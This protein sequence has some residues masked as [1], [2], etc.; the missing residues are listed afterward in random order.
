MSASAA[1]AA[2][3]APAAS[4]D[5]AR[6]AAQV[7][8]RHRNRARRRIVV[9]WVARIVLLAVCLA[10]WEAVVKFGLANAL[11]FSDPTAIVAFLAQAVPNGELTEHTV[12]TIVETLWGFVIGSVFGIVSGLIFARL[13]TLDAI[14][15]PFLNVLNALPRVALAPLFILWFGIDQP[16]KVA[17]AVSLVYFILLINTR[18]GV[19]TVPEEYII[20]ARSLGAG[21][22]ELFTK[23]ILPGAVPAIFAGLRLAAVYSLLGVVVGEMIAAKAGLG[24]QLTYYAGTFNT[25]GVFGV[26]IILAIIAGVLN[27]GMVFIEGRLLRWQRRSE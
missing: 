5:A 22:R 8:V 11:F 13:S 12:V 6:A 21:E 2:P 16:S 9:I 17:L 14:F 15:D 27:A 20:I 25:A 24:Q 18:A 23:V 4:D 10:I 7:A 3:A 19:K 26:L 1:P